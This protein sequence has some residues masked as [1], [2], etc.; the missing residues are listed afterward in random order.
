MLVILAVAGLAALRIFLARGNSD[1]AA[2]DDDFSRYHNETF[3]CVKVVD[4]D[5]IDISIPDNK[6]QK[7]T[8]YTR[9]RLWGIDTPELPHHD[10]TAMYYGY[11]AAEFARKLMQGKQVKLE[12]LPS[13]TRD[14][15]GRL[16][17]YVYL[18]DGRMYSREAIRSGFAYA[19]KRYRHFR[20]DEFRQLEAEARANLAG[21]WA[22][23]KPDQ[24]PKWYRQADLR[25]FWTDRQAKLGSGSSRSPQPINS[26]AVPYEPY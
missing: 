17:A 20:Q 7:H 19:D 4:G 14:Y 21:L 13:D 25:S 1:G 22:G 18:A 26:S 5:T 3:T 2:G 11:E 9:V 23:V 12:L 15:Y 16:L 24:L 6:S 10:R 8:S